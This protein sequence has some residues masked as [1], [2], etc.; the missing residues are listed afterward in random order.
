MGRRRTRRLGVV[1]AGTS[2]ALLLP[3]AAPAWAGPVFHTSFHGEVAIAVWTSCPQ[4]RDGDSCY[5]TVVIASDAR[6]YENS[7][8]E[9][10]GHFLHDSGDRVVLRH[11]WYDVT[12]V[13]GELWAV[14]TRES[15]GGT[16]V[17]VSVDVHRRLTAASATAPSVP[18]HTTDYVAGTE[19]EET[20]SVSVR[21]SPEGTLERIAQ[22]DRASSRD[23]FFLTAT[24]GWQRQATASGVDDGVPVTRTSVPG[25]T[26]L[27]S[28]R[29]VDLRVYKGRPAG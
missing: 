24:T 5:D 21:W 6:T 20:S 28:V 10:G 11:F 18:M 8:Q 7:D 13:D 12:E 22:R 15:F 14:P 26:V 17:G 29:Q 16:D 1:V 19:T 2:T 9:G 3:V 25:D 4:P 27:V 23:Y